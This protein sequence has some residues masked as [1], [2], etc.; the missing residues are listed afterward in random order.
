LIKSYYPSNVYGSNDGHDG[1]IVEIEENDTN[2]FGV[3]ASMEE[4]SHIL[5]A[6][7]LCLFQ[8][9]FIPLSKCVDSLT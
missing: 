7:E 9:L 3:G 5:I 2:I 1:P 4:F 8:K 6:R